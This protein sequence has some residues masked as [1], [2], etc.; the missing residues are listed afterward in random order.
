MALKHSPKN[1]FSDLQVISG[2]KEGVAKYEELLYRRFFSYAMSIAV[3]YIGNSEDAIEVVNDSFL[4][5]F[6][7]LSE[8][9]TS[10]PFKAWFARIVVNTAIDSYRKNLKHDHGITDLEDGVHQWNEREPMAEVQLAAEDIL[11]MFDKLPHTYRVIFNL[12]EIERY[13]HNEI[14][15]MLGIAESSSRAALTRAKRML[16]EQ[17]EI[18]NKVKMSCNG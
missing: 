13:S 17:Y 16:R 5:V 4:K 7:N 18:Y 12:Y 3:R 6:D 2:C 1:E 8:F 15:E 11:R 9:D 14:G 10:K